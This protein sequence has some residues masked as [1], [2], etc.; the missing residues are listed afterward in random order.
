LSLKILGDKIMLQALACSKPSQIK[1][2]LADTAQQKAY[3][4]IFP[5]SK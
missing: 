3:G 4:I 2:G 1:A 5:R